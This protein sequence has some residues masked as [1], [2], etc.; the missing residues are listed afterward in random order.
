MG[1]GYRF[2]REH[3]GSVLYN[4]KGKQWL[5]WDAKRW[6]EDDMHEVMQRAKQTV[7]GI[8][9]EAAFTTDEEQRKVVAKHALK[10]EQD[11]RMSGC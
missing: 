11:G 6:A 1:N 2:A 3:R 8:Y 10:S 7:K 4:V 9:H 5:C